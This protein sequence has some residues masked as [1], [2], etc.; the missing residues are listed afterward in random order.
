MDVVINYKNL[1]LK[2]INFEKPINNYVINKGIHV[3]LTYQ[4]DDLKLNEIYLETPIMEIPFGIKSYDTNDSKNINKFYVD[5]SFKGLDKEKDIIDFYNKINQLDNFIIESANK[6]LNDWNLD[7]SNDQV[8]NLY[9]NQIRYNHNEKF[10]FPPTFKLKISK[11]KAGRFNTLLC[12]NQNFFTNNLEKYLIP[13]CKVKIVMKCNGIW[14]INNKFGLTWRVKYI[15]VID[16]KILIGYS[17]I[18]NDHCDYFYDDHYL[19]CDFETDKETYQDIDY[20][21]AIH[22]LYT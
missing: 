19:L 12:K 9:I 13:G 18:D 11:N 22:L 1:K 3:K 16:S 15:K 6:N 8:E 20:D 17:F 21:Y 4:L 5:L 2:N 10:K 7:I 14:S